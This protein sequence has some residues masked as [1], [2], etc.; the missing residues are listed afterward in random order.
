[1]HDER[2]AP[3]RGF[4]N[5]E[6]S[7]YGRV[8]N[9]KTDRILKTSIND[10]GYEVVCLSRSGRQFIKKIHIM[11]AEAFVEKYY[12]DTYS[13]HRDYNRLNNYYD[14]LEWRRLDDIQ[15]KSQRRYK[16]VRTKRRYDIMKPLRVVETGEVFDSISDASEALGMS[17]S[18]I[19]KCLNYP[20]YRNRRGYHFEKLYW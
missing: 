20:Y 4:P 12:D 2:W 9:I 8:R 14:N 18:S 7:D 11:V 19:S 15:Q 17:A 3:I 16:R 5:Y 6:I 1:M 10:K 13:T